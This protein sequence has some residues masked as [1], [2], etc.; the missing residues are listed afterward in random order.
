MI[1]RPLA[2]LLAAA[3]LVAAGAAGAQQPAAV[4]RLV[5]VEG[6]VLVSQGDAMVAAVNGQLLPV[7]ARVITT[8][9][10]KALIR[11]DNGCDV[12]LQENQRFTVQNGECPALLAAVEPV[13]PPPAVATAGTIGTTDAVL[14]VGGLGAFGVG[15]YELFKNQP[16]SSN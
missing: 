3:V 1:F 4:A 12:P 9:G 14:G 6:N 7:G 11:Y 8:V 15:I 16:V 13:G 5:D 10:G 2:A